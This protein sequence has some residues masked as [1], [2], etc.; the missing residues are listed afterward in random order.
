[1]CLLLIS[2]LPWSG[3][4]WV[5]EGRGQW[6]GILLCMTVRTQLSA[7]SVPLSS[8]TPGSSA[9]S[10][11]MGK[12]SWDLMLGRGGWEGP[13]AG[14]RMTHITST[15][16][17]LART[18]CTWTNPRTRKLYYSISQE[19]A[20]RLCCNVPWLLLLQPIY[21]HSTHSPSGGLERT[22][23]NPQELTTKFSGILKA[24]C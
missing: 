7:S 23:S 15:Y 8:G 21:C 16:I 13:P 14:P 9:F 17:P 19:G 4:E 11:Q 5:G 12:E 22:G 2:G 24:N 10:R 1:M 6:E 20:S 18:Q 3:C